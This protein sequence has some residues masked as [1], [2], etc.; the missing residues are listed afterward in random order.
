MQKA[1][2]SKKAVP[3]K[4]APKKKVAAAKAVKK[5]TVARSTRKVTAPKIGKKT[6]AKLPT[7]RK[8]VNKK[9]V[10]ARK[11]VA[12]KGALKP[13][14]VANKVVKRVVKVVRKNVTKENI[15]AVTKEIVKDAKITEKAIRKTIH[16][17]QEELEVDPSATTDTK[18]H[19][20]IASI[21][22]LFILCLI[23]L[24]FYPKSKYAQHHAKQGVVLCL[25]WILIFIFPPIAILLIVFSVWGFVKAN[26]GIWLEL[27]FVFKISK[28]ITLE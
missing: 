24:L 18:D 11:K 13:K 3:K 20:F 21:S 22:Y 19:S 7:A 28:R 23:P 10:P 9:T 1:T 15:D 8:S 6:A 14:A 12:Q 2:T 16:K 25:S 26:K 27:P 4:A 17:V 5:S